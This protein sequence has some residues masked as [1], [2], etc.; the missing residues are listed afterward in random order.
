MTWDNGIFGDVSIDWGDGNVSTGDASGQLTHQY[1]VPPGTT[2]E[3]TI[4]I[5]AID[6]PGQS[7]SVTVPVSGP[8]A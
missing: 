3:F 6:H 7:Q 4:V 2:Q 8:E 1:N 5:T